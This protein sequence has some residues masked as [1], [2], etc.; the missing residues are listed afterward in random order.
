MIDAVDGVDGFLDLAG[1][2]IL[3]RF[4]R[5]TGIFRVNHHHRDFDIRKLVD[6]YTE[7]GK[8]THDDE[9]EHEHGRHDRIGDT[10]A[11]QPHDASVD[12]GWR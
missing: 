7:I 5:G 6:R 4:W 9:G 3:H 1:D 8:H 10:D 11:G 12:L 2:V